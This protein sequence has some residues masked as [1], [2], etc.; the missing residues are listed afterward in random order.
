MTER[1]S[2]TSL[3]MFEHLDAP[4][5]GRIREHMEERTFGAGATVMKEGAPGDAM[6]IVQSGCVQVR[7]PDESG[8]VRF[9]TN[10]CQGEVVGEMAL[11]T[12]EP[13]SADV[14]VSDDG[15]ATCLMLPKDKLDALIE[16]HT[17]FAEVLTRLLDQRVLESRLLEQIGPYHVVDLIGRGQ[18]ASVF[19]GYHG[20]LRRSVAIK[21]LS[22]AL[23]R[24][25]GFLER[26]R[27]EAETLAA[28][29]HP[30]IVRVHDACEG[31]GTWFIVMER[32]EGTDL[33]RHIEDKGPFDFD[34]TRRIVRCVADALH[35]AHEHGVVH[36]DVKPSNI[37]L[38]DAG[39]LK[40]VDFGVATGAGQD[41]GATL[42]TPA[43]AAPE[44]IAGGTLD[45]RAD[46]YALGMTA[47]TLLTGK[48][49]FD[50]PDPSVVCAMQMSAPMPEV[51]DAIP[52]IPG[53]L[54]EFIRKATQKE[55][56]DRF[57][58]CLDAL[59]HFAWAGGPASGAGRDRARLR[60]SWPPEA[61]EQAKH[62][63]SAV[64]ALLWG[65]EELNV[66]VEGGPP[67]AA[68][69]PGEPPEPAETPEA[70]AG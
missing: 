23:V 29:R 27:A 37:F 65:Y 6:Y 63:I 21:M 41:D 50:N 30:A 19:E 1:S 60:I 55:P 47:W 4:F 17:A 12:G 40:L 26:F 70:P 56:E 25:E 61:V 48:P 31:F 32:L 43:Y 46:V 13:R 57:E 39:R 5:R 49:A 51:T 2:L 69:S 62:A 7:V 16:E 66:V 10:L 42:G 11:L 35:H 44:V 20:V 14:V 36:R 59:D 64:Q 58:S 3:S 18:M 67:E 52:G 53:D 9:Q 28:L 45:R 24:R 38:D 22:H 15:P 8:G 33:A 54:A 68:R 34:Q